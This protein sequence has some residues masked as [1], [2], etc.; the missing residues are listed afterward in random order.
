MTEPKEFLECLKEQTERKFPF[1]AY[2]EPSAKGGVIKAFLQTYLEVYKTTNFS[3][4]GFVFAPFDTREEAVFIPKEKSEFIET[5]FTEKEGFELSPVIDY[6]NSK[7][8]AEKERHINIVQKAIDSINAG[9][10]RKVVLS[11]KE[12]LQTGPQDAI[13]LFQR[14]LKKYPD[15][16]VYLF[17]HP[18]VG[19]W[20]GATPE[21]LLEV[22]RNKFRTMALAGTQKFEGSEAVAWGE[23]EKEEQQIV[24]DSI[25]DSLQSHCI[26]IQ[27]S[28]PH[29]SRAGNLLHLRT[30]ISGEIIPDDDS[31]KTLITALHPT[32]AVCGL[33]KEPAKNFL[34]ET[35][36]YDREFYTG[37]LGEINMKQEVKR[38]SNRRNLENQAYASV[39][40][41]S[42]LY[43]NL[44]CMKINKDTTE[45]F[46]GG[47]ITKE[48]IP[49]AE[50]DETLHKAGTMK[51]VLE[52][53]DR[54]MG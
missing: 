30:N 33:P 39:V 12:V 29:T 16:F 45:V 8:I 47:G 42:S 36:N 9:K 15:A 17:H 14:L 32:P 49:S 1:V 26:N 44:R 50:W 22:E 53:L 41:S 27:K 46:V 43:V 48:S 24:T 4:S 7:E 21:T 31:L 18:L 28:E 10:F 54:K 5:I 13:E 3:E 37:F 34:L 35:E 6:S 40:K 38:S 20:L 2:R 19:T 11:R 52:M 23:K 25:F 51:A